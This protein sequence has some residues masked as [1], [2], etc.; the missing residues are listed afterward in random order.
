M[1]IAVT[2]V[3]NPAGTTTEMTVATGTKMFK[4]PIAQGDAPI[5]QADAPKAVVTEQSNAP[6]DPR[7]EM[8][9]KREKQIR[10]QQQK[11]QA[12]KAAWEA[13][14]AKSVQSY[15]NPSQLSEDQALAT[16]AQYGLTTDKLT[17]LLL[18][19]N[20]NPHDPN[21]RALKNEI[22]QI[23]AQQQQLVTQAQEAQEQQRV[24]AIRQ[25]DNEVK[26]L[27]DGNDAFEAIQKTGMHE[28]VTKLIEETFDSK[29]YLMDVEAAAKEVES[30][31]E[32]EADKMASLK[33]IQ[34]K[35]VPAPAPVSAKPQQQQPIK[36]LTNAVTQSTPRKSSEAERRERAIAAFYNKQG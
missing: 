18:N 6:A 34:A 27:V 16:L 12:E 32:A 30:F 23:R 2:K 36:T 4:A 28:A 19:T 26:L 22:E 35:Q 5:A 31:L 14:K 1:S 29:G 21:V 7:L 20:S 10:A 15:I 17:S 33:K 11:F 24:Q 8:L 13:E 9:A 25:I 3:P